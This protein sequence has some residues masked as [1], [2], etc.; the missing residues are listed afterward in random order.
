MPIQGDGGWLRIVSMIAAAESLRIDSRRLAK[1]FGHLLVQQDAMQIKPEYKSLDRR[2]RDKSQLNKK[3]RGVT[4]TA[5]V[6]ARQLITERGLARLQRAQRPPSRLLLA[7]LLAQLQLLLAQL[8]LAQLPAQ[9][10]QLT[11]RGLPLP[12][13]AQFLP[14][15]LPVLPLRRPALAFARRSS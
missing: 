10:L 11:L 3:G 2:G 6:C 4:P 12:L 14:L 8:L 15:A 9:F 1:C 13:P 7:L 5:F